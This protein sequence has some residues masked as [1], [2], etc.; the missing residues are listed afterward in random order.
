MFLL[1]GANPEVDMIKNL[2][3]RKDAGLAKRNGAAVAPSSSIFKAFKTPGQLSVK[4]MWQQPQSSSI[5]LYSV[6][7]LTPNPQ[8]MN[9]PFCPFIIFWL[10]D[11]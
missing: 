2:K 3:I 9:M 4:K 5:D 1:I 7:T 11:Y 10:P 6:N 8:T